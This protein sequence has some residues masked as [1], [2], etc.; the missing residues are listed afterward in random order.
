[1]LLVIAVKG[2]G[3]FMTFFY[4]LLRFFTI[5]MAKAKQTVRCGTNGS[6]PAHMLLG[7]GGREAECRQA[8]EARSLG[9]AGALGLLLDRW[10]RKERWVSAW[11][12]RKKGLGKFETRKMLT[13]AFS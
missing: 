11:K 2:S 5:K 7:W 10:E 6:G 4:C 12:E 9:M 13:S 1:M 3:C 8:R